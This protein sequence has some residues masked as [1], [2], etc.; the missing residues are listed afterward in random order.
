[1]RVVIQI[2]SGDEK[3]Q[4]VLDTGSTSREPTGAQDAVAGS[5]SGSPAPEPPLPT[6]QGT[7]EADA[8]DGGAAGVERHLGPAP[9]A[10]PSSDLLTRA[11]T[12][13]ALDGG[14]A[15]ST[16][17]VDAAPPPFTGAPP[18]A[19]FAEGEVPADWPFTSLA[20]DMSAGPAPAEPGTDAYVTTINGTETADKESAEEQ[21]PPGA[22]ARNSGTKPEHEKKK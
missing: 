21:E 16:P 18:S 13:G 17:P 22:K 9:S 14:P 11:R 6:P 8:L 19:A 7:V 5:V 3:P 1:M 2:D 20:V 12:V 4:I 15:P 10:T